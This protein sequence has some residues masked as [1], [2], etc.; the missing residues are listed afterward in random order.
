MY[1][2]EEALKRIEEGTYGICELTGKAIPKSRLNAI[3]WAR[4]TVKAQAQLEKDGGGRNRKI[5]NLGTIDGAGTN[6]ITTPDEV[7][8]DSKPTKPA[9]KKKK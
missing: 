6:T 5:G 8:A 1:E 2:I 3:P 4:Y 9:K 7:G